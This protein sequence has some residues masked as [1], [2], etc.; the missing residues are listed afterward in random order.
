[1]LNCHQKGVSM[2]KLSL[3]VLVALL[4]LVNLSYGLG[5][6]VMLGEPSG[7][8]AKYWMSG[9]NAIAGGLAWSLGNSD[10]NSGYLHLHADYL[11]HNNN[12]INISGT[13]LPFYYGLGAG[14]GLANDFYLGARIPVG[15]GYWFAGKKFD[16]FLELVPTVGLLRV[17][18]RRRRRVGLRI[19]SKRPELQ[20]KK[21]RGDIFFWPFW[22]ITAK[23][24]G[25]RQ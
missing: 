23:E 11:I 19:M 5:L 18:L 13:T 2:R 8:S 16:A 22:F 21:S 7:L 24:H 15:V 17:R 6:G 20:L 9:K 3:S 4:L 1:M 14:I 10:S 12:L 25:V